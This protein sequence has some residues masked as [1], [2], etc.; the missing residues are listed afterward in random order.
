MSVDHKIERFDDKTSFVVA[1]V[2]NRH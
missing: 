2:L 1:F